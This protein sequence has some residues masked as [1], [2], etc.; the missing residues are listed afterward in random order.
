MKDTSAFPRNT[1]TGYLANGK[2]NYTGPNKDTIETIWEPQGP[3]TYEIIQDIYPVTFPIEGSGQIVFRFS[4]INLQNSPLSVVPQYL[5]DIELSDGDSVNDG[6][7]ITTRYGYMSTQWAGYPPTNSIPPY[8]VATLEALSSEHFPYMLAEGYCNDSLAPEPM[9]LI[10]PSLFAFTDWR[11]VATSW[12]W[13]FPS[14]PIQYPTIGDDALLFQWLGGSANAGQ[15][16]QVIGSFSYGSP[17]CQP[18]CYGNL[19]AMMFHPEHIRWDAAG[20]FYYPSHFPVDAIVWNANNQTANNASGLQS[21]TNDASG[22]VNGPVKIVSPNAPPPLYSQTHNLTGSQIPGQQSSSISWEDTVIP[23]AL[24]N[25]STDSI[26]DIAFSVAAGGVT[27]PTSCQNGTYICPIEV[28]CEEKD[29]TPPSHSPHVVVGKLNSC[30][31]PKAYSD[32]VFDSL[33]TD[34]GIQSITWYALPTNAAV[35]VTGIP[36][37]I[38]GC[39]RSVGPI[40]VT[41]VDTVQAP[42]VYFTFTDCASNVS[43]DTVRFERCLPPVPFDTLPPRIRLLTEY[44]HNF[45][46]TTNTPCEFQC[47]QSVVT[48]SVEFSLPGLQRDGGLD[49]VGVASATN[50]SFTLLHP[51][52]LG[53]KVDTFSV[54]VIDS[55]QDGSIVIGAMDSAGNTTTYDTLSYCTIDD[56]SA[57][58]VVVSQQQLQGSWLV[59]ASETRPW[60]RGI[61]SLL[62]TFVEN[63]WPVPNPSLFTIDSINDST[64]SIH[65]VTTCPDTLYF[66]VQIADTFKNACFTPQA[67]DCAH[68]KNTSA[69]YCIQALTDNFCPNDSLIHIGPPTSDSIEVFFYDIHPGINYDKG[70]DSIIFYGVHNVSMKYHGNAGAYPKYL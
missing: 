49:T 41:Q 47:S 67:W 38:L 39:P 42:T 33:K 46:D 34:Q 29:V 51:V 7:P 48:D 21:I 24:L 60:D 36:S 52:T 58:I 23:G 68:N 1:P 54:C 8:F 53:L 14:S 4:V 22:A 13:G 63:C 3:N 56:D 27:Q 35:T 6:A 18:I 10:E 19:D 43:Y 15:P 64:C 31:N 57:P 62:L 17:A 9:N 25:C 11:E 61:D 40:T 28:D 37:P 26:Y 30:G 32:S 2:T 20:S 66:V 59:T 44:N 5:L 70:V 12:T 50:M 65:P 69:P 45:R 16:P 55:M